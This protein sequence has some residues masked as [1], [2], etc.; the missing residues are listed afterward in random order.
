MAII[1]I[2]NSDQK[3]INCLTK[4]IQSEFSGIVIP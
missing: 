3:I 2:K 4:K 1:E